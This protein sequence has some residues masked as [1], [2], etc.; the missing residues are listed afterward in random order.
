MV[1]NGTIEQVSTIISSFQ[2]L[3]NPIIAVTLFYER[4]NYADKLQGIKYI[5][6]SF[7]T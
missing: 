1:R 5:F 2:I 6:A 4:T 3:L 7:C